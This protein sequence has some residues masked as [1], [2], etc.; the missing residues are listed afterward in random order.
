VKHNQAK[1]RALAN[2]GDVLIKLSS[3]EEAIKVYQKQLTLS[4]QLQDK[5]CEASSYGSLG[6][7]HRLLRRFDKSLG[8][9]T[10]V[11]AP[12]AAAACQDRIASCQHGVTIRIT[13]SR[14]GPL[15][16]NTPPPAGISTNYSAPVN[17]PVPS[18]AIAIW[19]CCKIM[20]CSP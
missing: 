6:V 4:K 10:Q 5:G 18:T 9:H 17:L 12:G 15:P 14:P 11:L 8:F 19:H 2:M 20:V 3:L 16:A 13:C 1:Y 7:C